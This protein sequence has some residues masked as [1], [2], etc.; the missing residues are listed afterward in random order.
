MQMTPNTCLGCQLQHVGAVE[1][2]AQSAELVEDA[3]DRPDIGLLPIRLILQYL[4]TARA[5]ENPLTN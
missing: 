4:W 5:E 1:W 3:A 2:S